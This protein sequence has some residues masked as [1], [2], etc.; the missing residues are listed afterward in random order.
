MS[1]LDRLASEL[2]SEGGI[3]A[4]T[5]VD[6]GAE[7][8]HGDAVAAKGDGYPLLV[9][10]IR[11]GYLEHYGEGRVVRPEDPD[12]ALL[13]GDRL[14]ALGLE[15]LAATGDLEAVAELADVIA[16]CAQAHAEGDPARAEAVWSAG[17]T[18]VA[19][20]PS[21]DHEALKRQ[22]RGA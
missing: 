17:A 4:E 6:S 7:T 12:L 19:V 22:W 8:P 20:G 5:V 3:L 21:P 1:A 10:A 16:L 13:A 18:A 9:E 11:E 14:Y 15:R 2:R